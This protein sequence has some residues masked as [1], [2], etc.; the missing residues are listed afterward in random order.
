MLYRIH[1]TVYAV[2]SRQYKVL[3]LS[4]DYTVVQSTLYNIVHT[5]Y[6]VRYTLYRV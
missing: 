5:V 3:L 4:T 2:L 6:S 1:C